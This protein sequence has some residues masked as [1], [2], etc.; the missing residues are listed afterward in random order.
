MQGIQNIPVRLNFVIQS[1]AYLNF[2][3]IKM[4]TKIELPVFK[5]SMTVNSILRNVKPEH[6]QNQFCL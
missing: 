1:V 3:Q 6:F 4:K 5:K 2:F